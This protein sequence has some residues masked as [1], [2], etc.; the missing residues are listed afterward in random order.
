MELLRLADEAG[1]G[2]PPE[3]REAF[4]EAL[5]RD[6]PVGDAIAYANSKYF[7]NKGLKAKP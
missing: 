1:P 3:Y 2:A 6:W 7:Y 5:I 4:D